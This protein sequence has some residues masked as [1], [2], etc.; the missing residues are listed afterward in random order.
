MHVRCSVTYNT[1]GSA[2]YSFVCGTLLLSA[3]LGV[4]W[5]PNTEGM[6]IHAI[7]VFGSNENIDAV[8][9]RLPPLV[10]MS[11]VVCTGRV[12]NAICRA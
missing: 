2:D 4:V 3:Y 8:G 12:Y 5:G 10:C 9:R 11:D 1:Y 7:F 6:M